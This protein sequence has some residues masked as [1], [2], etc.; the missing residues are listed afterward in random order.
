LGRNFLKKVPPQAPLQKLLH[1]SE[2]LFEKRFSETFP[3]TLLRKVAVKFVESL[4]KKDSAVTKAPSGR[5]LPTKSGE[6]ERVT[7]KIAQT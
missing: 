4:R 7:M 5:E 6:G 1:Y 2:N 3:K